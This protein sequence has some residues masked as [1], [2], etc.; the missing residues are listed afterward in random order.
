MTQLKKRCLIIMREDSTSVRLLPSLSSEFDLELI[1]DDRLDERD[2]VSILETPPFAIVLALSLPRYASLRI[3][4]LI[5]INRI[6][7]RLILISGTVAPENVIKDLFDA[8]LRPPVGSE[9]TALLSQPEWTHAFERRKVT[10]DTAIQAL[11]RA[12]VCFWL[13]GG[14]HPES[15]A[16]LVDYQ[17]AIVMD[18]KHFSILLLASDPSDSARLR[19]MKEFSE[20]ENELSK[21]SGFSFTTKYV[22]S[23]RPD[24][25]TRRFLEE[26]PHIVHFSGH[27]DSSGRLCFE[28]ASGKAWPADKEAIALMFEPLRK[29]VK[30]VVLN[31]CYSG[32]Q[33]RLIARHTEYTFGLS[34]SVPDDAAIALAK[35]FYGALAATGK[36]SS[37]LHAARANLRLVAGQT[38]ELLSTYRTDEYGS[39]ES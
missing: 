9:L 32:E 28:D 18:S 35:G 7:V 12:A 39:S 14:R 21:K 17:R 5:A 6:H 2:I 8:F 16:T 10:I 25:L 27:G 36:V 29:Y 37:A 11:L 20:V 23:S 3:A 24:E 4:E 19:L 33:A 30:C 31:A 26:R 22:F 38:V 34:S 13:S 15:F 1:D